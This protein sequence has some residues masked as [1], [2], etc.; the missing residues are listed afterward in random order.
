MIHQGTF[1]HSTI[2]NI[3]I[4]QEFEGKLAR[5]I[6]LNEIKCQQQVFD[7][8]VADSAA[9]SKILKVDCCKILKTILLDNKSDGSILALVV[10]GNK[11]INRAAIKKLIGT[12]DLPLVA[13]ETLPARVGYPAG[14]VPPFG[15]N[16]KFFIDSE[17]TLDPKVEYFAGGGSPRSLIIIKISEI[18]KASSPEVFEITR[19]TD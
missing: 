12:K 8:Q 1:T 11:S 14:G 17:L 19:K 10:A 2:E 16:A 18:M 5:F 15:Y 4:W 13:A 6:S 9:C 7:Q 3:K